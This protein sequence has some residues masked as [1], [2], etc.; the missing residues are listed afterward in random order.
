MYGKHA[1]CVGNIPC[2]WVTCPVY[3][4]H[5]LCLRT[6]THLWETFPTSPMCV[7]LW[8]VDFVVDGVVDGIVD[9]LLEKFNNETFPVREK[10]FEVLRNTLVGHFC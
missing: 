10:Y 6:M 9:E 2:V 7:V 5:A 4:K 1:L 3:E 8:I